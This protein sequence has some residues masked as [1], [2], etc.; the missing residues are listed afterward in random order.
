M[1]KENNIKFTGEKSKM[2]CSQRTYNFIEVWSLADGVLDILLVED[3]PARG[4]ANLFVHPLVT[5][6]WFIFRNVIS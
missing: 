3:T 6:I 1:Y 4:V 2:S 5:R